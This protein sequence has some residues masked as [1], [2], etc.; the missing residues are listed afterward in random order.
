MVGR[1][2]AMLPGDGHGPRERPILDVGSRSKVVAG[3]WIRMV[4]RG[5]GHLAD[6]DRWQSCDRAR[7]DVQLSYPDSDVSHEPTSL[8]DTRG[9]VGQGHVRTVVHS[10]TACLVSVLTR[11]KIFT[12]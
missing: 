6:P 1:V 7:A 11:G 3:G 4:M 2:F 12:L 9:T 10:V 8:N 5:I